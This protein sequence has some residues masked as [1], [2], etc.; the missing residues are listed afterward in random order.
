MPV[1]FGSV[2]VRAAVRS[3]LVMVPVKALV[4]VVLCGKKAKVSAPAVLEVKVAEFVV[5]RVVL[6]TPLVCV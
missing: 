2:Q 5:V 6:K 1:A 3:A 4:V